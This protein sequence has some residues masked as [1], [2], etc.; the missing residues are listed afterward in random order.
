M[1]MNNETSIFAEYPDVVTIDDLQQMLHLG[2]CTIYQL[3]KDNEIKHIRIGR[4]YLIPKKCAIN[5]IDM[6]N[7]DSCQIPSYC[8]RMKAVG[9]S[10]GKE[11]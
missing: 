10:H 5:F 7:R 4:K 3:L 8:D 11:R 1:R 9:C 2:K 6:S